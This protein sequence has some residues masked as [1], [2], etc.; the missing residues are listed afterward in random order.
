MEEEESV[1]RFEDERTEDEDEVEVP[2]VEEPAKV[3]HWGR[4]L[5]RQ[6]WR[7]WTSLDYGKPTARSGAQKHHSHVPPTTR[8]SFAWRVCRDGAL[9]GQCCKSG[10]QETN[11]SRIG[12]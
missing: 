5:E 3:L 2:A 8:G 7:Q 1:F 9:P 6:R 10:R 12:A 11:L 4:M